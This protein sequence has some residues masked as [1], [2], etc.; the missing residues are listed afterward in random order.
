MAKHGNARVQPLL[1]L[2]VHQEISPEWLRLPSVSK[3]Q[4]EEAHDQAAAT[5]GRHPSAVPPHCGGHCASIGFGG[6]ISVHLLSVA[7]SGFAA[8][9]PTSR[10]R[11]VPVGACGLTGHTRCPAIPRARAGSEDPQLRRRARPWAGLDSPWPRR[12]GGES[13]GIDHH[14]RDADPP[15]AAELGLDRPRCLVAA[16]HRATGKHREATQAPA[17]RRRDCRRGCCGIFAPTGG[18]RR[19]ALTPVS[20]SR[21]PRCGVTWGL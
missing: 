19:R 6:G 14:R 5:G 12:V 9:T 11:G 2:R 16:L 20:P 8:T 7:T 10:V 17:R 18:C 21:Q 3:G 4:R 1:L 15:A 13:A